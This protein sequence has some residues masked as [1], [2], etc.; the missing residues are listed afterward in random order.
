[1]KRGLVKLDP[2]EIP[3]AEREDRVA[4]LQRQLK[5]AGI[6]VALIYGDVSRSDDIAYL[7][8]LCIYWNE[9]ILAVPAAGD[10]AF[11]TKL[12]PRVFGW[13]RQVSTVADI[14]SGRKFGDLAAKY[15]DG[16]TSATV[17]L[18]DAELW[19]ASVAGEIRQA[20][21]GHDVRDTGDLARQARLAPSGP[22][23]AL[24]RQAGG[25]LAGAL[26]RTT[27]D[28]AAADG[29]TPNAR[30]AAVERGLR[31]Q[32]FLDVFARAG[33]APDGVTSLEVTGQY[34][35]LWVHASRLT[36]TGAAA[37][38][39]VLE[40]A[41]AAAIGAARPGAT[42]AA[43][44]EAAGPALGELPAG[45]T[46]RVRWTHQAD[47][48]T[49]GEYASYPPGLSITSGAAVVITVDATFPDGRHAQVADTVA[50]TADGAESLTEPDL[51]A[52]R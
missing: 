17:G 7:T 34:R 24:L 19:P 1:M 26:G 49:G 42:A 38:P 52:A 21:A 33:D 23:L 27:A 51:E 39:A 8:N 15:L 9:G 43:L 3:D 25:L 16:D 40:R 18:I 31:G 44:A 4:R 50:V 29:L 5:D 35:A 20:L 37:W 45:A 48:A 10:P 12:S 47:M 30:I 2:A 11:L 46:A 13:M 32:G 36:D 22:E 6:D 14:H 41:L 28:G